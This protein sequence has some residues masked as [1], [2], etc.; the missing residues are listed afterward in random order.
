VG[1][2]SGSRPMLPAGRTL[3]DLSATTALMWLLDRRR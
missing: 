3:S 1:C 2:V